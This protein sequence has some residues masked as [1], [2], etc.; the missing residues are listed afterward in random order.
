LQSFVFLVR[1][2]AEIKVAG[3][4]PENKENNLGRVKRLKATFNYLLQEMEQRL[5]HEEK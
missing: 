5:F 3:L 2:K 1:H 4:N